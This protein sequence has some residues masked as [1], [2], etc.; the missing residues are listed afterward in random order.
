[1]SIDGGLGSGEIRL[2]LAGQNPG[3]ILIG[4]KRIRFAIYRENRTKAD[5]RRRRLAGYLPRLTLAR[6]F[7]LGRPKSRR[8]EIVVRMTKNSY[9]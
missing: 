8:P 3:D 4:Q 9:S 1:M 6:F 5:I 7:L 2:I